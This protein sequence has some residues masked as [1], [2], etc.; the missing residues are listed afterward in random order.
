MRIRPATVDDVARIAAV[1]VLGWQRGYRGLLPGDVLDGL[2]PSQRVPRW[3]ATVERAAWPR[4]GTLVAEQ[5]GELLGFADLQPARDGDLDPVTVGEVT[6][7][8][9]VPAR[10]R[11]GV[12]RRLMASAVRTLAD[13]GYREATLWVLDTNARA[14]GFYRATGWQ[15]DGAVKDDIVGGA[16]ITDLRYRR[17]LG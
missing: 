7:F 17:G 1:H 15:P 12:G 3:R 4:R 16:H 14:M 13:A 5:D 11:S 8:Y 9:V 10:W 6:S 2:E